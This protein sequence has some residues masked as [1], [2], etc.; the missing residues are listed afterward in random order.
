MN[1]WYIIIGLILLGSFIGIGFVYTKILK[2]HIREIKRKMER[3]YKDNE[4]ISK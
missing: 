4:S 2:N 1:I 3:P